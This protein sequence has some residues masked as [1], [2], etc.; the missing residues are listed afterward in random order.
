VSSQQDRKPG[1]WTRDLDLERS[2]SVLD[3]ARDAIVSIRVDGTVTDFNRAAEAMFGYA[4]TEIIGRNVGMLMPEP[5]RHEHDGYIRRYRAAG[6]PRAIGRI[7]EVEAV[8][9]GGE[10][11]PIELSVSEVGDPA[12]PIYTA[13]IRDVSAFRSMVEALRLERDFSNRLIDAAPMIVL[14]L[15]TDGSV[16]RLNGY[17]EAICGYSLDDLRDRDALEILIHEADRTSVREVFDA[18]IEGEPV[19]GYINR[20]RTRSG[21]TRTIRW[22]GEL[23]RGPDGKTAALLAVG[24]D[25]TERMR[26]DQEM[27]SLEQRARE[28]ERLADIGAIAAKLVHDLGNPLSGLS[29]QA[30]LLQRRAQNQAD[31]GIAQ[32]AE[33]IIAAAARL[34]ELIRS[35]MDF[36][37]EQRLELHDVDL[38]AMLSDLVTLWKPVASSGGILL[39]LEACHG[40]GGVRGDDEKLR[41]VFDNLIRNAIEAA[42]GGGAVRLAVEDAGNGRMRVSVEDDGP[43]VAPNVDVFRL[44]ETTKAKGTGIGLAVAKQIVV[45]HGGSIGF[46]NREPHGATFTV[47]LPVRGPD[48]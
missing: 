9:K 44:F 16:V 8:R 7:R 3:N 32:P 6:D 43:G 4:A 47:E 21:E 24:E 37:R 39:A 25:I 5:Y 19:R 20:L 23:L 14:V 33:R 27:R 18:A 46:A 35:F 13:I 30:Q 1:A 28:R 36:A 38:R 15:A 10:T 41:R 29:M 12:D 17:T 45:A 40:A 11:F 2:R 31:A 42:E 26:A 48:V 22:S 34:N